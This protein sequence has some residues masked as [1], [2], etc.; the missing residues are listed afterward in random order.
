MKKRVSWTKEKLI[1][2]F[3][4]LYRYA[5]PVLSWDNQ[6]EPEK[7]KYKDFL[8]IILKKMSR[9][10]PDEPFT[11]GCIIQQINF[12]IQHQNP[13]FLRPGHHKTHVKNHF[14]AIQAGLISEESLFETIS[15][16]KK[17]TLSEFKLRQL[18]HKKRKK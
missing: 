1:M 11:K 15:A 14:Y 12:A 7:E 6:Y 3:N 8:E 18:I 2:L 5:G 9:T 17:P 16:V 4:E 13:R 10:Y